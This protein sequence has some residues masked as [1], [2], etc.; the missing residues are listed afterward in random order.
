M[1]KILSILISS[2]LTASMVGCSSNE[3][4]KVD[5]N[6]TT[7]QVQEAVGNDDKKHILD[8]KLVD[9]KLVVKS[10]IDYNGDWNFVFKYNLLVI[11]EI[12]QGLNLSNIDE[13]QYWS[14]CQTTDGGTKKIFSCTMGKNQLQMIQDGKVYST[15][16]SNMTSKMTDL[17]LD[18]ELLQGLSS[19]VASQIIINDTKEKDHTENIKDTTQTEESE[20]VVQSKNKT[21]KEQTEKT[22]SDTEKNNTTKK[23]QQK[24][25]KTTT[26][27]EDDYYDENGEYVGP[28]HSSMDDR[29]NSICDNC[30]H[31]ID[32]CI[33]DFNKDDDSDEDA[34]INDDKQEFIKYTEDGN[35]EYYYN[36]HPVTEE[37]YNGRKGQFGD[38]DSI[39]EKI[40]ERNTQ[41]QQDN[42]QSQQ[43]NDKD[44]EEILK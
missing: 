10:Q 9:G 33:C 7:T 13:L 26:K 32:D 28:K 12:A 23:V 42:N 1:K 41:T 6:N 24:K 43:Y 22:N 36:G 8:S 16:I 30:K 40:I 29:K 17:Y 25:K 31:P 15:D 39:N 20:Q 21:T 44:D 38:S 34:W 27:E 18:S 4:V 11:G 5:G 2:V 35:T 14:V 19:K 37:E 3:L